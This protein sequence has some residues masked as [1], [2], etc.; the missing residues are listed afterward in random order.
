[1]IQRLG[2]EKLGGGGVYGYVYKGKQVDRRLVALKWLK[3][4]E[5]NDDDFRNQVAIIYQ[6]SHVN[7]V[8]LLGYCLEGDQRRALVYEFVSNGSLERFIQNDDNHLPWKT[9]LRVAIGIAQGLDYLHSGC[10]QQVLHYD[11]KPSNILLDEDFCPKIS[12]YG[13][14]ILYG[15]QSLK[16]NVS[17]VVYM[18]LELVNCKEELGGVVHSKADVYSYEMVL[19]EMARGKNNNLVPTCQVLTTIRVEPTLEFPD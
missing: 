3:E 4:F 10:H 2:E 6:V 7:V 18:A 13:F 17:T 5:A 15:L 1:M 16:S 19:V 12:Y 9:L 14:S 8:R 11:I